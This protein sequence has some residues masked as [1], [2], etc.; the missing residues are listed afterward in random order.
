MHCWHENYLLTKLWGGF[1]RG[2]CLL[3]NQSFLP[4]DTPI[5]PENTIYDNI[6]I[7]LY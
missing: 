6:S 5:I 3:K 4:P 1:I 2:V 7:C